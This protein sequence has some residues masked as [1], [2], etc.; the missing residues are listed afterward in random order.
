MSPCDPFCN[1]RS[2]TG[3]Q[4][5]SVLFEWLPTG[6]CRG[7]YYAECRVCGSLVKCWFIDNAA[8]NKH[9]TIVLRPGQQIG[10]RV[11]DMDE[12]REVAERHNLTPPT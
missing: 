2:T 8:S 12:A 11:F 1:Y 4:L 9:M 7:I 3:K 6:G 5:E 10:K